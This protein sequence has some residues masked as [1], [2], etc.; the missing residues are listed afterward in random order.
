MSSNKALGKSGEELARNYLRK[1]G[2]RIID[3]NFRCRRFGEIDLIGIKDKILVFI[4][5]KCRK[6]RKFGEPFEAVDERKRRVIRLIAE[7]YLQ[8]NWRYRSMNARFDVISIVIPPGGEAEIQH[9]EN[10]F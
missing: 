3:S 9:I 10:A 4:E 2:F 7:S 8:K 6:N 1:K 5:V